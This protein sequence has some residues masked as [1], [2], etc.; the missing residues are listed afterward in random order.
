ML[1]LTYTP[2]E[3]IAA[4]DQN[5]LAVDIGLAALLGDIYNF[6]ELLQHPILQVLSSTS[7]AWVAEMLMAFNRGDIKTFEASFNANAASNPILAAKKD[8]LAQKVRVMAL[9]DLVFTRPSSERIVPFADV[10]SSCD[11]KIDQVEL[12]AMKS[13]SLKVIRGSIDQLQQTLF[14]TWVQPRV[15]DAAQ[16][17][18]LRDRLATWGRE[19]SRTATDIEAQAPELLSQAV[20]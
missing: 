14:F 20:I 10:A 4:A 19:V 6:G 1:Y 16:T 17:T 8:F 18:R 9:M 5:T 12:L 15:L 11:V 13:F 3:E 7:H 2:L